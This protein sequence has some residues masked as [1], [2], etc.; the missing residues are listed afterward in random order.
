MPWFA[1]YTRPKNEKKVV[2]GLEKLGIEVYCPMVTQVKQWSDRKKKVEMP[3]INS[4][5]FVNIEDKNRNTVFEV[6]GVVRYLFWLG[7]PAVIQEQEIEALKASLKGILSAVEVNGIQ[8][9]DSLTISKG[10]FQGKEGVVSQVDKNKIRLVLKELGVTIT[11][12][13][14]EE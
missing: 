14:E 1:I 12:S 7:K 11:I 13:K 9:G 8:P 6:S 3:L 5:V 10:P 2:E 4:Y